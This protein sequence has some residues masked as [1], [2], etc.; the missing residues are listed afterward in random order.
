MIDVYTDVSVRKG[1][2]IATCFVISPLNFLGCRTFEYTGVCSALQGE[3]L[4]IR[5]GL[6]YVLNE[7]IIDDAVTVHCDSISAVE[8]VNGT[9]PLKQFQKITKSI[10]SM[11][12]DKEVCFE[13]IKGHQATHNPNK[14]VDLISN[15]VLMYRSP[16]KV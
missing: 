13:Y 10:H 6:N 3:L 2:A 14:I 8:Q 1:K 7:L 16:P 15:S 11:C 12:A 9:S 5:D 4:G